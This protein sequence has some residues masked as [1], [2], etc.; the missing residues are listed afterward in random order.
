VGYIPL[1]LALSIVMGMGGF[2]VTNATTYLSGMAMKLI[3]TKG[4]RDLIDESA[5]LDYKDFFD[6]FRTDLAGPCREVKIDNEHKEIILFIDR[7]KIMSQSLKTIGYSS[8]IVPI[9]Y[10][11]KIMNLWR[12]G[13]MD[14]LRGVLKISSLNKKRDA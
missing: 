11:D 14:D 2:C 7:K 10:I 3:N 1:W 13:R 8:G 5:L 9:E 6:T 4:I 12:Y